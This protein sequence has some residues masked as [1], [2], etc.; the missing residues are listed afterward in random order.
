MRYHVVEASELAE[1]KYRFL[2]YLQ[3][4]YDGHG[5]AEASASLQT[6]F[7][8]A[9]VAV[10]AFLPRL[11][12]RPFSASVEV[13]ETMGPLT[14]RLPFRI[15]SGLARR[16]L[17]AAFIAA[18][19]RAD[20][21]TTVAYFWPDVSLHV[22]QRARALGILT[23]R[24][25]INSPV[26]FAKVVLDRAYATFG[27]RTPHGAT[28]VKIAHEA[29]ELPLYDMYAV[30]NAEVQGVMEAAGYDPDR[31]MSTSYGW[32]AERFAARGD[33]VARVPNGRL[34]VLFV[35][36]IE[37][38]KGVPDLLAAWRAADLDGVLSLVGAITPDLAALVAEHVAGGRVEHLGFVEEVGALYR[39][40]DFFVCP[41]HEEGGPQVT[42]EAGG[43]GLPI[44][45]TPMGAA[46]FVEEGV[47]G[48]IVPPGDVA[49]LTA[50]IRRLAASPEER[51]RMARASAAKGAEFEYAAVGAARARVIIDA[52]RRRGAS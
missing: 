9:G 41:S 51:G 13:V 22:L 16:S 26:A 7:A 8:A 20:P 3:Y 15:A 29:L 40:A 1:P 37:I 18:M 38:R 24:E 4:S 44:I 42:V 11:R 28:D 34:R 30:S 10:T 52:L 27:S 23:V 39:S 31:I 17:D 14:R 35:G 6:G 43:S 50:A 19:E 12:K 36:T 45:A 2:I 48:I 46:R 32:R 5:P 21:A 49:A 47:N 25:M 33:E